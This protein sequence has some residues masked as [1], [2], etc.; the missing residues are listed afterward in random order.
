MKKLLLAI[1]LLTG[2]MGSLMAQSIVGTDPENKNVVLEEFTGL[3]CGYC[4]DGHVIA[5]GIYDQ[6]PNDVVLVNVHVG[7]FAAP[8]AGQPDYRTPWGAALDGQ[9]AVAGYPAGTVNR[10][11]F[12]G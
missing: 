1:L 9:A 8:S 10:H 12:P 3:N 5:Q 6:H 7:S 2:F 4:P 11:L